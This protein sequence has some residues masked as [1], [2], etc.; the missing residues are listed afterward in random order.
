MPELGRNCKRNRLLP[1]E[2]AARAIRQ[3][4]PLLLCFNAIM[5]F[6]E[7]GVKPDQKR[8]HI[9]FQIEKSERLTYLLNETFANPQ[10]PSAATS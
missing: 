4:A 8:E 6:I 7:L 5:Y 2:A 9:V 10:G 3:S 1:I